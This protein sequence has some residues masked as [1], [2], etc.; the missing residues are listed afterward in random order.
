MRDARSMV[1]PVLL[2]I[3]L[4]APMV[5]VSDPEVMTLMIL[6]PQNAAGDIV[7]VRGDD[8]EVEFVVQDP[9]NTTFD[10]GSKKDKIRLVRVIDD[11]VISE[12][13]TR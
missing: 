9:A 4:L 6:N 1:V 12:K 5:A 13:K 11:F 7:V 3:A 8:I 10:L 2:A